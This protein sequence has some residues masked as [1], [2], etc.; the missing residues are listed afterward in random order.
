ME[1]LDREEEL[2]RLER[3]AHTGGLAVIWGRRRIG[4][5]RLLLQW[6]KQ[7]GGMY[8]VADQSAAPIQRRYFAVAL[9]S[10]FPGFDQVQYPD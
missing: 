2:G 4:K 7:H 8:T 3:L 6:C 10:R 9:A 1:F 5:T